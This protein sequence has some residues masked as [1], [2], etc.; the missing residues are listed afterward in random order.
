MRLVT[1]DIFTN[2]SLSIA[3]ATATVEA[4]PDAWPPEVD[5]ILSAME[6]ARSDIADRRTG[7]RH[8]RRTKAE[9]NLF[10]HGPLLP[11]IV[12]Y[13]RD[14]G[15]GG[16]GFITRERVTLGYNGMVKLTVPNGQVISLHCAVYRCREAVNGWYEGALTFAVE[17]PEL[18]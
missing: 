3:P 4:D 17:H 15:A 16:I 1:D 12:L 2:D 8:P 14:I 5:L 7:V 6:A 9:L 11:P 18:A 13:T 10:A